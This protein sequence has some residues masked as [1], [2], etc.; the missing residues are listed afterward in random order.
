MN[1]RL[2]SVLPES[3]LLI[4]L[5]LLVGVI[6]FFS[7]LANTED[8]VLK[9]DVFFLFLLPP[10]VLEAGYFLPKRAFFD[11]IGTILMYAIFGTLFNTVAIGLSLYAFT[12]YGVGWIGRRINILDC[13]IFSSLISAVDPVAVLSVFEDIHVNE[14]LHIIVFGESLLNDAVT[15]VSLLSSLVQCLK[16]LLHFKKWWGAG[17]EFRTWGEGGSWVFRIWGGGEG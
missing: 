9:S 2:S 16:G 14:M 11:N 4:V 1:N 8:Y 7:K 17:R 3:T 12:Q 15:V 5:G 6:L 10:I 13:M